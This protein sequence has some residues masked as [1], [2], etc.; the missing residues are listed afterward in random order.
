MATETHKFQ[1]G[2]FVIVSSVVAV[3]GLIWL[4]ASRYFEKTESFVTYFNESVQGLDVGAAVKFRGVTAGRVSR[5]AIAPDNE[6][7]EVRMAIDP[8]VAEAIRKDPT[9]RATLE[10]SGITGL[11][12]VEIDRR[13]G[14]ALNQS[15]RLAFAPPAEVI[16]SA[17]SSFKAIQAA[18]SDVYDRLMQV[19]Y[20][21]ISE[22]ARHALQA[23]SALLQDERIDSVLTNLKAT[24]QS[25][26]QLAKNLERMTAGVRLAPAVDNATA[27]TAEAKQFFTDLTKG[28]TG[29]ELVRAMTQ[30]NSLVQSTQQA[31]LTMQYT[32]ERLDRTATN[33]QGLTD[34][35]RTQPSRLLFSGP[36]EEEP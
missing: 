17:R 2:V 20:K 27:A 3:A 32:L 26:Q 21:G 34:Q 35:L 9:V 10:L 30:L 36:P 13:Q 1:V 11:R 19:D 25:A 12:Y 31:V 18:L 28:K 7:I 16:P 15:P 6:L 22:D 29:Q 33:L 24:T 23:A 14:D 8:T 4:G 5:I